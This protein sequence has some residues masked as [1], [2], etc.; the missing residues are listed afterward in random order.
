VTP[1]PVNKAANTLKVKGKTVTI[2]YDK[3]MKKKRTIKKSK[4]YKISK[5]QGKVTFKLGSVNKKKFKKKFK[6]NKKTG[7]ITVKKGIKKGTYKV[8]VKI[9]A[10]GNAKYKASKQK[11]ATVKIIIN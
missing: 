10:A 9:K 2:K 11:T 6:V 5:A 8:K 4:A 7:T 1:A 3:V